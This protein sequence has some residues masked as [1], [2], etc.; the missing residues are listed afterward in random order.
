MPSCT[1]KRFVHTQVWPALRY[2]AAIA[3]STARS[4]SASSNTMKGALPP[5]SIETFFMVEA[6][7]CM[8]SLPTS[9]E[10][11]KVI[12]L[13][14]GLEVS[15]A[16]ISRAEPVTM[17]TAPSGTPACSHS[18]PQARAEKGVCEAGLSTIV[19]PAA[20]AAPSLRAIMEDG[21]FQGVIAPTTPTGSLVTRILR[22]GHGE[23]ITSP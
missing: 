16:P 8:R 11:V 1:R 15:S 3:P 13:T 4:R 21:K 2:L 18:T 17:L 22:L 9:V 19:Q 6:D 23:G 7:C 5:S 12:F 20:S 14:V 10:P